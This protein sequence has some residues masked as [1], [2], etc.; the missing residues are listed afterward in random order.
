MAGRSYLL[1]TNTLSHLVRQPHGSVAARIAGC[2]TRGGSLTS[3]RWICLQVASIRRRRPRS[4]SGS[5]RARM[6]SGWHSTTPDRARGGATRGQCE[7]V[8]EL[9]CQAF[10]GETVGAQLTPWEWLV[11]ARE[12]GRDDNPVIRAAPAASAP[13]PRIS[14]APAQSTGYRVAPIANRVCK[15]RTYITPRDRAG[16]AISSS[17][18][19]LVAMWRNSRPAETTSISPSSFA[20]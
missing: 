7:R 16:V 3:R 14:K 8:R 6:G 11:G 17:P 9:E 20:G 18:I 2:S 15:P 12:T 5:T 19:A 1:D 10:R 13:P 4:R